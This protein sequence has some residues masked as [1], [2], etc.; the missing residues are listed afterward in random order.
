MH[1]VLS[2]A[3]SDSSGGAGIQADIKT[4]CAFKVFA[5]TAITAVV[6]ENT[7]EVLGIR[8]ME[9]DFVYEQI[10]AVAVDMPPSAV[11][12]GMLGNGK[13]GHAVA[14]AIRDFKLKNIVLD[15]VLV[16]SSGGSL[17]QDI[18]ETVNVINDELAPLAS[19]ITPNIPEIKSL[20]GIESDGFDLKLMPSMLMKRTGCEAVLLKGGHDAGIQSVDCLARRQYGEGRVETFASQ[21]IPT[22]NNHGTGCTLS[23][24]VACGLAVGLPLEQA[25]K[26]AKKFVTS[27]LEGARYSELGNGNGPMNFF[28][29]AD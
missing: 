20:L 24:A 28:V 26:R 29:K 18:R 16:A 15:P 1:T 25:I 23:S 2:V 11:K 27:A 14:C 6:A 5:T 8:A 9:P 3:G 12:I 4:C 19:L 10:K 21:R 17:A 13:V 7:M 22:K